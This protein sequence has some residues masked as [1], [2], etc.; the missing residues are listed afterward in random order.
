M[1]FVIALIVVFLGIYFMKNQE[2]QNEQRAYENAITSS[3]PLVL[4]N[5]LDMYAAAPLAHRDSIKQHLAALKKV[6]TDWT[7]A[8][9]NN[10]KFGYERFLK[11]HPNSIH[12]VEAS[13]KIDSLDW[14]AATQENTAEAFKKYMDDHDDGAYYDEARANYEQLEAQKVTPEDRSGQ[15]AVYHLF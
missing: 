13:I 4:Q 5:F 14:L 9:V 3:E 12:S 10:S 1:A 11:L 7:D 8:L 6:D 15:S 2:Q